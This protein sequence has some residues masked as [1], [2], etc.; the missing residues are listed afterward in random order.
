MLGCD[1]QLAGR[2]FLPTYLN[3]YSFNNK[4]FYIIFDYDDEK[5]T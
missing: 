1:A 2:M 4:V 3:V 5:T